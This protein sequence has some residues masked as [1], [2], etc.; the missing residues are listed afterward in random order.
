MFKR[1][2]KRKIDNRVLWKGKQIDNDKWVIC[3]C[4]ISY[5]GLVYLGQCGRHINTFV[6]LDPNTI[7][8]YTHT[9]D[10]NKNPIFEIE[11]C[12][13]HWENDCVVN[14]LITNGV[15]PNK[16]TA[17]EHQRVIIDFLNCL[18][19][20]ILRKTRLKKTKTNPIVCVNK[21]NELNIAYNI[22]FFL[23]GC[24]TDFIRYNK[25]NAENKNNTE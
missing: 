23:F 8:Q 18:N 9:K 22:K 3:R 11:K 14:I 20:L 10:N 16:T 13:H 2:K 24:L 6:M 12:P 1:K 7:C 15:K 19:K 25:P 5:K 21:I 4:L 17:I